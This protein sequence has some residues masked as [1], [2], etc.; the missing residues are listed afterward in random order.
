M[1]DRREQA[2]ISRTRTA[3][4]G[5]CSGAVAVLIMTVAAA[6]SNSVAVIADLMATIF[7][8]LAV[9]FAWLTLRRLSKKGEFT[10]DYGYGKLENLVSII[11]AILMFMSLSLVGLN[12]VRRFA[13]P[14]PISGF[15]VWLTVVAHGVYL[16]INGFLCRR[17]HLS[18]KVDPSTLLEAQ[19]RLFAVKAFCNTCMIIALSSAM[20]LSKYPASMY[21]DPA[22]SLVIAVSMF[23]GAYRIVNQNLGALLDHTL[24][25]SLQLL[26]VR[27][28]AHF[29]HE[30]TALHGVRSRRSGNQV[31]VELF[32]EFDKERT[33]GDVQGTISEMK[34]SL[35]SVIPRCEV[36][37]VPSTQK[38]PSRL[39]TVPNVSEEVNGEE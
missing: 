35:E 39:I 36:C 34:K 8:W 2:N 29:F 9:V 23:L 3:L 25:E 33:M 17:T 13:D 27:E 16:G 11:I 12:A 18:W 26:I 10:F 20:F 30:Y 6:T 1:S 15:G 24:E 38:P 31:F 37:I 7:E 32:L 4:I 5:V 19:R 21:I 14:Q 28:L 22:M